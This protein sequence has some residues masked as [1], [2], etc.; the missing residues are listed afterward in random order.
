MKKILIVILAIA[1]IAFFTLCT[2]GIINSKNRTASHESSGYYENVADSA[3]G[4]SYSS[5]EPFRTRYRDNQG[6]ES[7][8]TVD[9]SG[10][11]FRD[12]QGYESEMQVLDN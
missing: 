6:Y 7:E 10:I 12:N 3:G 1:V 11:K 8:M 4:P 9:D 2:I 5:D